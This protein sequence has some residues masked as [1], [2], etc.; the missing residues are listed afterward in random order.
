MS[1]RPSWDGFI[2]F[3]LISVP[4]KAYTATVSG[5][6]KIGFHLI[7]KGCNNRIRYKKV[8]PVHGEVPNDEIVSAYEHARGEYIV[9]GD[10]ERKE[11]R[12][13]NDKAIA[14]DAFI[15]PEALDPLYFT[16]RTYYL[17]PDGKVAQ[18]PYAVLCEAMADDRRYAVAQVVFSGQGRVAVVR[19]L[20][21]VLAMTLLSYEDQ[22]KKPSSFEDEVS[23]AD[24]TPE[25]RKLAA[26]LIEAATAKEFDLGRYRDEY[27]ARLTQLLEAKGK[28]KKVVA[29]AGHDEPAVINLMDA[30]RRSLDQARHGPANGKAGKKGHAGRK[31]ARAAGKRKTG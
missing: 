22:V 14:I 24:V 13:E 8:C 4:V 23:G 6:G 19:P 28:G 29:A 1:A 18:K 3:N 20:G 27:T 26:T 5:G 2:K 17:V 15:R 16:E 31:A 11:L 12:V 9:V 30:L 10:D 7:H 25:E 21:R